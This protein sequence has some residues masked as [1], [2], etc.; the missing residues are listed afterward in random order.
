MQYPSDSVVPVSV[1]ERLL[2]AQA[3]LDDAI[4][5]IEYGNLTGEQMAEI[6]HRCKA[7]DNGEMACEPWQAVYTRLLK[8]FS[9]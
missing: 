5:E 2:M 4:G 8:R 9:E 1:A 7:I 6:E 3:L